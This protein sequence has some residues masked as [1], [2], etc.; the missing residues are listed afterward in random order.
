M[1]FRKKKNK[2][3]NRD[4]WDALIKEPSIYLTFLNHQVVF[5][6]TE[7]ISDLEEELNKV[8]NGVFYID[9]CNQQKSVCVVFFFDEK[10]YKLMLQ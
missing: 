4:E 10:D 5:S 8:C 7:V 9:W 1:E 2:R 6:S 3:L